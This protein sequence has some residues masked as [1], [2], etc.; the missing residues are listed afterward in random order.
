MCKDTRLFEIIPTNC[1]VYY[2][3]INDLV[4]KIN[5]YKKN[6]KKLKKIAHN[7]RKFYNLNFNS[8][9]VSQF[10]L[11]EVFNLK[12]KQNYLWI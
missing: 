10:I 7:G 2:K 8:T 5:F 11:D 9:V 4:K 1:A 6:I 12:K 3:N